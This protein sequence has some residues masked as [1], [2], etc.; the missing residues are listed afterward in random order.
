MAKYKVLKAERDEATARAVEAERLSNV[1]EI[2][3]LEAELESAKLELCELRDRMSVGYLLKRARDLWGPDR[4]SLEGVVV[5]LSVDL[6]KLARIA[7]GADKDADQIT[8][9]ALAVAMGNVIFSMIRWCDDLGIDPVV[10]IRMAI[11]RQCEF[12]RE[13]VRR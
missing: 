6:G 8:A 12:A 5:R 4:L 10:C 11:E 9:D 2:R 13:N 3:G 1:D 7:R